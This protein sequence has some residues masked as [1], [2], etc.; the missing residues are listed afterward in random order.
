MMMMLMS[1]LMVIMMVVVG[2][3]PITMMMKEFMK[4][5]MKT[6]NDANAYDI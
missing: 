2:P 1:M 3:N 6:S 5:V 4:Q